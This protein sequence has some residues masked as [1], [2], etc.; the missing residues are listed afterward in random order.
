MSDLYSFSWQSPDGT[1]H[2]MTDYQEKV[3]I[4]VNTA[5]QCGLTPQYKELQQLHEEFSEKG[6]CWLRETT[7]TVRGLWGLMFRR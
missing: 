7:I 6:R 3:V 5:S 1:E 2:S 4:I